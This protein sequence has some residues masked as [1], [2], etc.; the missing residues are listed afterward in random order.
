MK[1]VRINIHQTHMEQVI[2]C[3]V[4]N[5]GIINQHHL[6]Y[7]SL[8]RITIIITLLLC[9]LNYVYMKM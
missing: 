3:S 8:V 2:N 4:L 1:N 6:V 5:Y 9:R 7:Y